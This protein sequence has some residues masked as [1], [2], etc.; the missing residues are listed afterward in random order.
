MEHPGST[1]SLSVAPESASLRRLEE[2]LRRCT[3][4]GSSPIVAIDEVHCVRPE[5]WEAMTSRLPR[6]G[7][8]IVVRLDPD[9]AIV[10]VA[11]GN[12]VPVRV[13]ESTVHVEPGSSVRVP[14]H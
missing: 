1:A 10:E 3:A 14:R 8:D 6:H 7:S 4:A 9:G 12:P 5:A 2:I 13:G 11:T